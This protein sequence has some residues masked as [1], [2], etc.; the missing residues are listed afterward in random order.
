MTGMAY[1]VVSVTLPADLVNQPNGKLSSSV[2]TA[3][4]FPG[5]SGARL[6]TLA[7]RAFAAL[8]AACYLATGVTLSVTSV[9]DAYRDFNNQ[10]RTFTTRY[11]PVSWLTYSLTPSSRRKKWD[12]AKAFGY[13]SVYWVLIQNAD[14]SYPAMAAV[15]GTSNHGWGLAIDVCWWKDGRAVGIYG[16]PA[17][18]WLL[19]NAATYGFSW[20]AQSEPWH[21]RYVKGSDL[22]QAVLDFENPTPQPEWPPFVPEWGLFGLWPWA[23]GKP[24][25]Q[26]GSK[27]DAVRYLQG[28]LKLRANQ[29]HIV[30]DGDF[31]TQT[32]DA[33]MKLQAF[34]GL[35][36]DGI[37]GPKTWGAV[38][39]LGQ[40]A[41]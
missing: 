8:A 9:V 14:G 10:L 38:D 13:D 40:K 4:A 2:L 18:S 31:G 22:P 20:E 26:V 19:A 12:N 29:T 6:H 33:V 36:V 24:T 23:T 3:V 25:L 7:A 34:F 30:V 32:A 41:A 27:G 17:W 21:I 11:K 5:R 28:V 1:P 16:S 39:L 15:P 35:T 37:V